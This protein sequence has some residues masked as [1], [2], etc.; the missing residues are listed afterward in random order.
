MNH[1]QLDLFSFL[2]ALGPYASMVRNIIMEP[3]SRFHSGSARQPPHRV[4]MGGEGGG[5]IV[6]PRYS[7]TG[8]QQTLLLILPFLFPGQLRHLRY[9]VFEVPS[10]RF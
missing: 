9:L 8:F 7:K 10:F 3:D 2:R 5:A 1:Q 4:G 6:V